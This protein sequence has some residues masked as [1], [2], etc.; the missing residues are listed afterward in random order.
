MATGVDAKLLKSTK[1]PPE[2]NQKVDMTKVNLQVMKK[3]IAGRITEILSNEDDVVIELVFN[4]IESS[5]HPD[6]KALQIQL[7]GFLDKDT[8][9]FCKEMWGLLLSAQ[10]SPQGVP[11]E[12]LEAKKLELLQEKREQEEARQKREDSENQR[13][14]S[15]QRGFGGRDLDLSLEALV[16]MERDGHCHDQLAPL[17]DAVVLAHHFPTGIQPKDAAPL[18]EALTAAVGPGIGGTVDPLPILPDPLATPDLSVEAEA[19]PRD[20]QDVEAGVSPPTSSD[21]GVGAALALR[22]VALVLLSLTDGTGLVLALRAVDLVTE[23][24]ATVRDRSADGSGAEDRPHE[25][26]HDDPAVLSPEQESKIDTE[27][28]EKELK[29]KIKQMRSSRS[30]D[31]VEANS[32]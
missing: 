4:L 30:S 24:V 16:W 8:P 28:R 17:V 14:D 18:P 23:D 7:T 9:G 27:Q 15:F 12:L 3:W 21:I 31:V 22:A 5:R 20:G 10:D 32:A 19:L 11:K 29:E 2:F 13:R 1:F 6:I 25:A 26:T